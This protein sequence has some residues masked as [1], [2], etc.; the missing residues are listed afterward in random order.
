MKA[1]LLILSI[2]YYVKKNALS[3]TDLEELLRGIID[4]SSSVYL[5]FC[6]SAESPIIS[7][8]FF[9]LDPKV[10]VYGVQGEKLG[11]GDYGALVDQF[12]YKQLK[13]SKAK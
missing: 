4:A 13:P 1:V 3:A 8:F 12:S 9:K 2:L 6:H 7:D 11:I 10:K 5:Q